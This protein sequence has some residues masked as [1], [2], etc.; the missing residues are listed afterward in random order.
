MLLVEVGDTVRLGQPLF[1]IYAENKRKMDLAMR[2]A[3]KKLI[4]ETEK[5]I[6]EKFT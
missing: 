6:L 4:V 5:I 2:F 1:Q 3:S